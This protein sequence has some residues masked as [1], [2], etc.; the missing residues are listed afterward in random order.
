MSSGRREITLEG[1]TVEE[2]LSLPEEHVQSYV[3]TGEP[4]LVE[5]AEIEGGGEG[6]LPL[7]AAVCERYARSRKL[8]GIEWIVHAIHCANP[9]LK[10]R[11]V[12]ER[13]GFERRLLAGIGEAYHLV[14]SLESA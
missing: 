12:L 11:R 14:R 6:A 1:Y 13:R 5:L 4:L 9:N 3:F 7:L 10:L 8:A 2:L